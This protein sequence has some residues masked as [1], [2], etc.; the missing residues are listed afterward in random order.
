MVQCA[1]LCRIAPIEISISAVITVIV[2]SGRA[3]A[4]EGDEFSALGRTISIGTL[5]GFDVP[6]VAILSTCSARTIYRGWEGAQECITNYARAILIRILAQII[7]VT[8][9]IIG[10]ASCACAIGEGAAGN[11]CDHIVTV[12]WGVLA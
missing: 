6:I 1:S 9:E 4:N 12:L 5:A 2:I 7:I 3:I 10:C 8:P 11:I